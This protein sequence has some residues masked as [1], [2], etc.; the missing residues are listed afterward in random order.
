MSQTSAVDYW[1]RTS[2]L[3]FA[4]PKCSDC[5]AYHFYPKPACPH[6]GSLRVEPAPAEPS[7]MV[8]GFSVVHRAPGPEFQQDVPYVVAII[9]TDAGPHLMGRVVEI[10]PEAV[11]IGMRVR[12]VDGRAGLAP[13]FR[14]AGQED[15]R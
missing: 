12:V 10:S 15:S 2:G 4:L 11:R 8:Y 14:A 6:C 9:A 5:G 1:S 7:G 13:V 3:G